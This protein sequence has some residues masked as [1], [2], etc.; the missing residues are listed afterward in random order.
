M[1]IT[2]DSNVT[3]AYHVANVC[4]KIADYLDVIGRYVLPNFIKMLIDSLVFS[5]IV[6]GLLYGC[7][8][9][10]HHITCLHNR[11]DCMLFSLCKYGHV[12]QYRFVIGWLNVNSVIPHHSLVAMYMQYRYDHCLLLNWQIKFGQHSSFHTRTQTSFV[13]I[14]QC[15]LSFS[16]FF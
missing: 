6:H 4:K 10:L 13:N 15:N 8:N 14:F 1:G 7:I 11:E 2:I 9:F 12:S 3:W 5:S 16:K